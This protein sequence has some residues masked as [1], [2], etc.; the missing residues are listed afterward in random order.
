MKSAV[1]FIVFNRPECANQVF[2]EI[3]NAKPPRLYIAADGPRLDKAED[4]ENCKLVRGIANMVDWEC[5]VHTLFQEVNL[6]CKSGVLAAINWFFELEDEGII[7]EDD[8]LPG[9]QF[10][11]YLELMLE[12]YRNREDIFMVTGYNPLGSEVISGDY[13][14]SRHSTIWGWATWG[15]RWKKYMLTPNDDWQFETEMVLKKYFTWYVR[16]YYM[17][18]FRRVFMRNSNTWDYQWAFVGI[19]NE[20]MCVRPEANLVSNIGVIGTHSSKKDKNHLKKFGSLV[21][22]LVEEANGRKND[23]EFEKS[24]LFEAFLKNVI[25]DFL[26]YL[27]LYNFAKKVFK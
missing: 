8:V 21:F 18:S 9:D 7:L 15:N 20:L 16:K 19:I 26:S 3:R 11:Y 2:N 17:E 1:L 6:G 14:M 4:V 24:I 23:K 5:E 27:R 22:P 25:V 12:K 10:F 13:F